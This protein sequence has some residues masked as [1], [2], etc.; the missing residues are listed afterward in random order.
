MAPRDSSLPKD[1]EYTTTICGGCGKKRS[2]EEGDDPEFCA[3]CIS[4]VS[5]RTQPVVVVGGMVA[6]RSD[7]IGWYEPFTANGGQD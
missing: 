3:Y 1:D 7:D 5:I 4:G 2:V 6:T